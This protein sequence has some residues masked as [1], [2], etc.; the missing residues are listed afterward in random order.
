MLARHWGEANR[1]D[2]IP[3]PL[4]LRSLFGKTRIMCVMKD[5]HRLM[6][7]TVLTLSEGA[8]GEVSEG[9]LEFARFRD[10]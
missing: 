1:K 2:V 5:K 7:E 8:G 9:H 3:A 10:E 4:E 6:G